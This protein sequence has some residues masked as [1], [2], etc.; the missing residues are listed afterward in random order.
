[1][2]KMAIA[3][4]GALVLAGCRTTPTAP[5]PPP[6]PA[7]D[8]SNPL[9]APGYMTQ[10]ASGDQ[11]EIQSGQLAHQRTQNA[12][13]HSFANMLVSDH[14]RVTQTMMSAAQSAGLTP[15]PPTLLP[16]HQAMLDQLR[17]AGS[18]PSFDMAFQQAQVQAHTEA[19]TLHQNYATSGDNPALRTV[20]SQAVPV[21]QTHLQHAQML[22]V[23]PPPAP[24]PI[25]RSG[26]RG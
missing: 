13:V 7:V 19:L 5:P 22:N 2:R 14:T 6:A 9:F 24:P 25:R 1:M 21:I 11:F 8:P 4:G 23:A 10:A 16:H 15:P 20:A 26:E 18:G 17:A 12:A 3:L